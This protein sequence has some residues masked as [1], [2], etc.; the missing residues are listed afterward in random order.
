MVT[1]QLPIYNEV[2]VIKRLLTAVSQIDYPREKLEI[3][4]LDDSTDE[5]TEI[6][7]REAVHL[8]HLGF[9]VELVRRLDRIGFKAGALNHGLQQAKG[10]FF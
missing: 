6:A 3:Q 5:T 8:R 1:V 2:Y 4:I 9:Q 7:H 10:E